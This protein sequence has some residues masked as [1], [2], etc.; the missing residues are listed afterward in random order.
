M[1][2]VLGTRL[3]EG[4]QARRLKHVTTKL[5][6]GSAPNY[7]DNGAVRAVSQAANQSAGLDWSRT[8][9]HDP[10]GDGH[11][12]RGYLNVGDVLINSTGT[13]TLGRIGYF[14][15]SPDSLPCIADSHVTIARG[16]QDRLYSRFLYYWLSSSLFQ[17][18][19]EAALTVGATNQIELNREALAEASLPCPPLVEQRRI[20]DF[21]D[22]ETGRL[23]RMI[24]LHRR[25][26]DLLAERQ[27]AELRMRMTGSSK[28]GEAG[29]RIPW[30]GT[31]TERWHISHLNRV[32]TFHMG[33]TFPHAFQGEKSGDYPFVKVGDFASADIMGNIDSAD[34]W[35]TN[36]TQRVLGGRVVPAGSVIYARVG[37]ALLLNQR[38]VI[39]RK[40]LVDDNVRGIEFTDG[41]PRFWMHLL[42][43]LDMGQ[44]SNPGPVPSVSESQ[45]AGVRVPVPALSEQREIARIVD[46]QLG[47]TAQVRERISHQTAL[48]LERRQAL[49]TSAVTGQIDV[50][51][52]RGV[53]VS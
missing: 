39:T 41:E 12:I 5:H 11:R 10:S 50:T 45:V 37:G 25:Q 32:G 29:T 44:L 43:L 28:P 9:L 13:G 3:P 7:A 36:M 30:L 34:N 6:R 53:D 22:A 8:R 20:A 52:A 4:W 19:I 21:L 17:E 40:C 23:D 27:V 24:S 35:V 2:Y 26:A 15:G 46:K 49:V 51:T 14:S 1:T 16:S 47:S 48:M 31:V 38:R 18:Y 42:S 33:T